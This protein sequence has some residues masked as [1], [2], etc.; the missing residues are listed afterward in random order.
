MDLKLTVCLN[1]LLPN[2]N[3]SSHFLKTSK[4][5]KSQWSPHSLSLSLSLPPYCSSAQLPHNPKLLP[6][7]C[8]SSQSKWEPVVLLLDLHLPPAMGPLFPFT[9]NI[10]SKQILTSSNCSTL[11]DCAS[12]TAKQLSTDITDL[13]VRETL[14]QSLEVH[15]V[16][17]IVDWPKPMWNWFPAAVTGVSGRARMRNYAQE[18]WYIGGSASS[19]VSIY[20]AL[21]AC[22]EHL[23]EPKW[24]GGPLLD[25]LQQK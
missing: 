20:K 8:T 7:T 21:S 25:A 6:S 18:L 1:W 11:L 2:L 14:E 15:I 9:Y 23:L 5:H 3:S 16:D 22:S 24:I 19:Q 10:P 4:G 13:V 17:H 12:A